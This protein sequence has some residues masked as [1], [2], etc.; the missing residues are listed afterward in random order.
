MRRSA[1]AP[2]ARSRIPTRASSGSARRSWPENDEEVQTI[3]Q[4]LLD[5]K[6][7]RSIAGHGGKISIVAVRDGNLFIAVPKSGG[8][9]RELATVK[10]LG[11]TDRC[12][13]AI[14]S[15]VPVDLTQSVGAWG[16][17]STRRPCSSRASANR[18]CVD[19]DDAVCDSTSP[20]TNAYRSAAAARYDLVLAQ[21]SPNIERRAGRPYPRLSQAMVRSTLPAPL[22]SRTPLAA[23][24]NG[25]RREPSAPA[26]HASTPLVAGRFEVLGLIGVGGMGSVYRARDVALDEMVA[27]KVIARE[28]AREPGMLERFRREVKLARRVTHPNV[29]RCFD[30][31]QDGDDRFFTMELVDGE[32]LGARLAREPRLTPQAVI[33][34]AMDVCAGLGAAHRAGVVH[35]DLKPDNV[36]LAKDGRVV[37]TDFGIASA[38]LPND[39]V[40]RT[41]GIIVGTPEYMAPEQVEGVRDIDGRAD[42]YSL[43]AMM[44]ELVT[45]TA[46]WTGSTSLAVVAAR[47]ALDPPDPRRHTAVDDALAELILRCMA[48]RRE[49]RFADVDELVRALAGLDVARTASR[50]NVP[51]PEISSAR[52]GARAAPRDKTVLVCARA[53]DDDE[54]AR[55]VAEGLG[56]L[57]ERNLRG[58]ATVRVIAG[59][60][61]RRAEEARALDATIVI[62]TSV[63]LAGDSVAVDVDLV[64]VV[65]DLVLSSRQHTGRRSELFAIASS[66]AQHAAEML[67]A[68]HSPTLP[69]GIAD[70]ESLDLWLRARAATSSDAPF[71]HDRAVA[72]FERAMA[73]APNDLWILAGYAATLVERFREA[74]TPSSDLVE[75][76]GMA[77]RVIGS[78]S[79]LGEAWLARAVARFELGDPR[80]AV[81][82]IARAGQVMPGYARVHA[83]RGRM[84]LEAG[85]QERAARH[86]DR[87]I[88]L[89]PALVQPRLDR[90]LAAA[91][92]AALP[93]ASTTLDEILDTHPSSSDAWLLAAR[94]A[95]WGGDVERGRALRQRLGRQPLERHERAAYLLEAASGHE[96][97]DAL[98][99]FVWLAEGDAAAAR[100]SASAGRIVAELAAARG[101]LVRAIDAIASVA[102]TAG[103]F[104]VAWLD[105][106]PLL[107][108]LRS[109]PR[110]NEIRA[111]VTTTR[112]DVLEILDAMREE[113]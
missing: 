5:R 21:H 48:R 27:L 93:V 36:L 99:Y 77:E 16:V 53:D 102:A 37:L 6:V 15:N 80:G 55:A 69:G 18:P 97:G 46:A 104:D 50:S 42:I 73:R 13:V 101:D 66:I 24:E 39:G 68:K 103:F 57:I 41:V 34:I 43:G 89:E 106:C 49:D 23:T 96:S 108:P 51:V 14:D 75:A 94:V 63:A 20:F 64:N 52:L 92:S 107:A 98:D 100:R 61:I 113:P 33:S 31:G 29:A 91:M 65:D 25:P 83:I 79:V 47:L 86:L 81:T 38:R 58:A 85:A 17:H 35:R 40:S 32:S 1:S 84:L 67:L 44:F 74:E 11:T 54:L 60:P 30:I 2:S 110:F 59:A 72:M 90:A 7:N 109:S 111:D 87:A 88:A 19:T 3:V 78:T 70:A 28:I 95:L 62:D 22:S 26:V 82:D 71:A 45:G 56:D 112:R 9:A 105:G 12:Q 8:A 10:G 76:L 4:E